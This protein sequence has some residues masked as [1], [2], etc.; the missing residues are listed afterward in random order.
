MY[1]YT[2]GDNSICLFSKQHENDFCFHS[3]S[4]YLCHKISLLLKK[5]AAKQM[6]LF[7]Q[8]FF[9][10]PL[11]FTIG[12]TSNHL[13]IHTHT[14]NEVDS[15]LLGLLIYMVNCENLLTEECIRNLLVLLF[16]IL[17]STHKKT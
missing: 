8:F 4:L 7:V 5:R 15:K 9:H 3:F 10:S 14:K 17:I 13:A 16:A 12:T 2:Y 6:A 11:P 1:P